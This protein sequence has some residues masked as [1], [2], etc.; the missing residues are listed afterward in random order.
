MTDGDNLPDD[1]PDVVAGMQRLADLRAL[2][3][4]VPD[5]TT[6]NQDKPPASSRT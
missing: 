1:D 5:L 6:Y 3:H 4:E 2:E